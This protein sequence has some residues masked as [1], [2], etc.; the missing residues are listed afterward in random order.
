MSSLLVVGHATA[1]TPYSTDSLAAL[2]LTP[3]DVN[4]A[5]SAVGSDKVTDSADVKTSVTGSGVEAD[6]TLKSNGGIIIVALYANAD[7]SG[8]NDSQRNNTLTFTA[9]SSK[10]RRETPME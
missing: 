5:L 1:Q 8:P 7:G 9:S 3:S 4:L 6:R 2:V 10:A